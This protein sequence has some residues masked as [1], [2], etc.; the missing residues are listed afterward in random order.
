M[1]E[2]YRFIG[3]DQCLADIGR[4]LGQASREL[5]LKS[6][7]MVGTLAMKSADVVLSFEM[8]SNAARQTDDV[9][10]GLPLLGAKTLSLSQATADAQQV[11]RCT[12][13]LSVVPVLAAPDAA[14]PPPASTPAP[15]PATLSVSDA[16]LTALA[17]ALRT[18]AA[19][20]PGDAPAFA[21]TQ[22][23]LDRI[24][25]LLR[26]RDFTAARA[27]LTAFAEEH[28]PQAKTPS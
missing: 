7:T 13:T 27:A 5:F 20:S 16:Q 22:A 15:A 14:A 18:A 12:I 21:R 4:G 2:P 28:L 3:V 1:A 26:A 23:A 8:T 9:S 17:A 6:Q 11:N 19:H 25:G 10:A 24:D